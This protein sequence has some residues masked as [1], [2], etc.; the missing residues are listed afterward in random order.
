[1]KLY[2][3]QK[4]DESLSNQYEIEDEVPFK[5]VDSRFINSLKDKI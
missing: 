1:M 2:A 5:V 4:L 3:N